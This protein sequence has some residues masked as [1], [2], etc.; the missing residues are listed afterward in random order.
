MPSETVR[1]VVEGLQEETGKYVTALLDVPSDD[2]NLP[3]RVLGTGWFLSDRAHG[4]IV[5]ALHVVL[6]ASSPDRTGFSRGNGAK[7]V[8]PQGAWHLIPEHIDLS[9]AALWQGALLGWSKCLLPVERLAPNSQGLEHD[10]LFVHGFP[11]SKSFV[12]AKGVAIKSHGNAT[13]IV[14]TPLDC[15][16]GPRFLVGYTT[17]NGMTSEGKSAMNPD[18]HGMSGSP[19]WRANWTGNLS[20]WNPSRATVI[21]V[22]IE[23]SQR[24]PALVVEPV[25]RLHTFLS[26]SR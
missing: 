16:L 5:T 20:T 1:A 3:P 26:E 2:S 4:R 6:E 17:E 7:C 19:V 23:W 13:N 10:V 24:L 15:D 22:A 8:R 11:A 9:T 25:E 21:G 12:L 18:P 14:P